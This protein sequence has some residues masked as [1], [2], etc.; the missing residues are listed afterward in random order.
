MCGI[1]ISIATCIWSTFTGAL[2]CWLNTKT[3]NHLHVCVST[4]GMG[5]HGGY[6]FTCTCWL[7]THRCTC[8]HT[9]HCLWR[10]RG[11]LCENV[12]MFSQVSTGRSPLIHLHC[13]MYTCLDINVC[14]KGKG[15]FGSRKGKYDKGKA[16]EGKAW[17]G[18]YV[19][20]HCL[21]R[22]ERSPQPQ[23][24]FHPPLIMHF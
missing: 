6:T 22:S 5:M 18:V 23:P 19:V 2:L 8:T 10:D 17:I 12:V 16:Q 21:A 15:K 20:P 1:S 13:I 4:V 7:Y 11:W 14:D 24:T 3:I 9:T